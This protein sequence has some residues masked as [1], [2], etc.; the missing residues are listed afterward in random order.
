MRNDWSTL[1][2]LHWRY[3]PAEVQRLL[4]PGLEV[5]TYDGAAWVA[6]V[7]FAMRVATPGNR[8]IPWA[9]TFLET[10]VRT[11][12]RAPDDT[13]GV[14]F[15]SLETSRVHVTAVARA[16]Y[17]VPYCWARL[18]L[19]REG[20]TVVYRAVRRWPA[21]RGA[22]SAVVVDVGEPYAPEEL[23]ELDHFLTARFQLFARRP[24][25]GLLR[26]RADHEPWSLRRCTAQH[27]DDSLVAACGLSSPVGP[28]ASV[29][30]AD[31]I[32]VKLGLPQRL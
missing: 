5:E 3:D 19:E 9:T 29:L 2:F 17:R 28:P 27:I 32:H 22:R 31:T 16:T 14:W 25:G 7:P 20:P 18:R 11:Y 12:V 23:T 4:P 8:A 6:L 13:T 1:T 21:P 24:R 10:N 26:T 30:H 15:F